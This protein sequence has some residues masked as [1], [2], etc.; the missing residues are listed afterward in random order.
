[1]HSWWLKAGVAGTELERREMAMPQPGAG[2]MIVHMRASS[3]NRGELMASIGWHGLDKPKQAGREVAGEVT[4]VGE[5]VTGFCVGDRIM[6]RAHGSFAEY[7]VV[8]PGLAMH[9]PAHLSWEQ[10][11]SIP[12]AFLTAHV[13]LRGFGR[14]RKG[15]WVLVAGAT[16]GVGV[17]AIQAACFFGAKV[18][19]TSTSLEKLTALHRYGMT[20]GVVARGSLNAESVKALTGGGVDLAINLVGGSVFEGALASL[21]R[22]GRH[23]MVGY[24]DGIMGARVDLGA[25]HASRLEISGISNSFLTA[26][27][28]YAETAAF[29]DDM[30][31]AFTGGHIEPV[32]DRVFAFDEL[33]AAKAYAESNSQIGKVVV[34]RD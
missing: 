24:V 17:A 4:V 25:V 30:L 34:R 23:V 11:G 31:P 5:G 7:V 18:I 15:E 16:S 29:I 12:I 33:P 10:A 8:K 6:A 14:L 32:I 2:E 3:L 27:E 20:E 26:E 1:M 28:R 13:A 9:M 22:C 21:R 19:G